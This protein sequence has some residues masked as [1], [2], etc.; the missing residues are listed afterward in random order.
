MF[1]N[2]AVTVPAVDPILSGSILSATK[3]YAAGYSSLP[4]RFTGFGREEPVSI[5]RRHATF[6]V[7][8]GNPTLPNPT[9]SPIK[10][11]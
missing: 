8:K 3:C 10:M 9:L 11:S 4:R 6:T 5:R 1:D 2:S 7:F